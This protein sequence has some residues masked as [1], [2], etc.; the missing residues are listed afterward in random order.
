MPKPKQR[1]EPRPYA[2]WYKVTLE[3]PIAIASF[4]SRQARAQVIEAL[5]GVATALAVAS[6]T[7][8]L[9]GKPRV[10]LVRKGPRLAAG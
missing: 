7:V 10:K 5:G 1:T 4:S 8:F 6:G 3:L 9:V 2:T